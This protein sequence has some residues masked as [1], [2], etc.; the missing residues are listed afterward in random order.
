MAT[1]SF[2]AKLVISSGLLYGYYHLF[3]RNKR[4]HRYNRF[5]LLAIPLISLVIPFIH[6]PVNLFGGN[7]QH[8]TIIQTLKVINAGWEEPV[9]IYAS[10]SNWPACVLR[11]LPSHS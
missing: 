11:I 3:L 5:Y 10:Q 2:I 8:S 7:G 4:F 1:L 9:I 6:I